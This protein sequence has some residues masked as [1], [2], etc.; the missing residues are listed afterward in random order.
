MIW[1]IL[2]ALAPF[3]TH[4]FPLL[5][6]LTLLS[7]KQANCTPLSD[8]GYFLCLSISSKESHGSVTNFIHSSIQMSPSERI[9]LAILCKI[10]LLTS[11]NRPLYF[12]STHLYL[13]FHYLFVRFLAYCQLFPQELC[14]RRAGS[15]PPPPLHPSFF[16][17]FTAICQQLHPHLTHKYC[18]TSGCMNYLF[19]SQVSGSVVFLFRAMRKLNIINSNIISNLKNFVLLS[20]NLIKI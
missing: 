14:F 10:A 13:T 19:F 3:L 20:I 16:F 1:N 6:L 4:F 5:T 17:S 11:L 2:H 9:F 18:Q 12:C 8:L 7:L 15:S